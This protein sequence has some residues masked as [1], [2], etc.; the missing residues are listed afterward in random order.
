MSK[1]DTGSPGNRTLEQAKKYRKSPLISGVNLMA[2]FLSRLEKSGFL[3][4]LVTLEYS[5]MLWQGFKSVSL[6]QESETSG[7]F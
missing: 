6:G 5:S 1:Y 3:K 4:Q 2:M 7:N